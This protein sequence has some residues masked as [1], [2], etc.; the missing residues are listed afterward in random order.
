MH[1]YNAEI[2]SSKFEEAGGK[3]KETELWKAPNITP[4]NLSPRRSESED[5]LLLRPVMNICCL[6]LVPWK[7]S[8][9]WRFVCSRFIGDCSWGLYMWS[10]ERSKSKHTVRLN[11]DGVATQTSSD[12]SGSPRV[13]LPCRPAAYWGSGAG[14]CIPPVTS[15]GCRLSLGWRQSTGPSDFLL[16]RQIFTSGLSCE[17]SAPSS[18]SHEGNHFS[19]S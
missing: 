16:P 19:P 17:M 8:V 5:R 18:P 7:R 10:S 13:E 12:S 2:S 6:S 9:N 3:Q 1:P 11:R 14:L 4:T 15:I